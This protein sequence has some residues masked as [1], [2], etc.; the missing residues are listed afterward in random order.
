MH[1]ISI[2]QSVNRV[3]R[4]SDLSRFTDFGGGQEAVFG[5]FKAGPESFRPGMVRW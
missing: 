1:R 2:Y 4:D 5:N 3:V